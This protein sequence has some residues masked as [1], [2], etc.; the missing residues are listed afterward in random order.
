MPSAALKIKKVDRGQRGNVDEKWSVDEGE[1]MFEVKVLE[2]NASVC[3]ID[4]CDA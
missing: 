2:G 1:L 4:D 3:W